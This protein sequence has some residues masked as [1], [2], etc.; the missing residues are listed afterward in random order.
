M[1]ILEGFFKEKDNNTHIKEIESLN[2]VIK[3]KELEI[4]KLKIEIQSMKETY[5]PPKQVE[6]FEKNLKALREENNKLKKEREDM[7]KVLNTY[8]KENSGDKEKYTLSK[9]K[10]KLSIDDFFSGIKFNLV[11]EYLNNNGILFIQDLA[12]VFEIKEFT[13]IK[14]FAAAQKKYLAFH[15]K[16]EV[17]WEE[18]ISL[19]KGDKIQ[20]I[21]KKS[22]KF[23]NYLVEHNIEFMDDMKDFNFD[24]LAVKGG[25]SQITVEEFKT[26]TQEYFNT[27]KII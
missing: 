19:C 18:R 12:N 7:Q 21:F 25:F 24:E 10:Y 26:M 1:G 16:N 9:F 20:K 27:Y 4:Q 13:K 11:R 2:L 3:E 14:N 5:I 23:I 6:I 17:L 8:E 22:R 15:D